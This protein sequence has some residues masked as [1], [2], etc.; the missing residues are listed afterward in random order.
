MN[1]P[2]LILCGGQ[3]SRVRHLD[4][5]RPKPMLLVK[6]KPFLEYLLED[7]TKKGF[8]HFILS[9]GY[10]SEVIEEYPWKHSVE[11]LKDTLLQGPD[12][13]L[14]QIGHFG[15]IANGDTLVTGHLPVVNPHYSTILT[16]GGIDSGM[17]YL[18]R[19]I[20]RLRVLECGKFYDIG[21][22]EGFL[23]FEQYLEV[24]SE[25]TV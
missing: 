3:G 18:A 19:G 8:G 7:L 24:V 9:T 17:Q 25:E 23:E 6:G 2:I 13:A 10:K 11:F 22:P 21:T 5:S 12:S 16:H 14:K 4:P 15:W 20:T 1:T